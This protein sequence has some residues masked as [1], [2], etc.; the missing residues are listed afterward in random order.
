MRILRPDVS[1]CRTLGGAVVVIDVLRAFST[2]TYALA[3]GARRV[4]AVRTVDE[5]LALRERIDG[6]ITIGA[7]PGGHRVPR[8][9][10]GNS[11]SELASFDLRGRTLILW[12]VG[13]VRALVQCRSADHILGAA[14]V[15]A[16]ATA[17][18]LRARAP[19]TVNLVVTGVWV[20][21]DGDED[22]ACADYLAAMLAGETPDP[23]PYESRVRNSDFGRRFA[24]GDDSAL[25][26]TDLDYCSAADRFDFAVGIRREGG[27]LLLEPLRAD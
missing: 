22:H 13:G 1:Q 23:A 16:R 14:M 4:I 15:N 26:A 21:R 3:H 11:P 10:A 25:P 24:A 27:L 18:W 6:A 7:L 20:D 19:H 17:R 12:T 5:A 9:D 8:F 2:V